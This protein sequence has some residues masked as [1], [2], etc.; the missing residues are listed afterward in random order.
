MGLLYVIIAQ[1]F[2]AL[3]LI[4]IRKFFPTQN[5]VAISSA[6]SIIASILYLPTLLIIRQK[7]S[8]KDIIILIILSITSWF[9]AQIFYITGIQKG[10]S[11]YAITLATLMM[12]LLT[13]IMAAVFLKE[14]IT[15]KILVG[16]IIMIFGFLI[17]SS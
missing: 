15:L 9:L 17:I 12:P 14:P 11:A 13:F 8:S 16:G 7:F 4:L 2:W 1:F 3:E 10:V 6:T 5:S